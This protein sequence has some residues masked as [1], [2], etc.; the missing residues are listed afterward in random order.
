MD[1]SVCVRF[2]KRALGAV[3][4]LASSSHSVPLSVKIARNPSPSVL[5]TSGIRDLHGAPEGE[6]PE[7]KEGLRQGLSQPRQEHHPDRRDHPRRGHGRVDDRRGSHGRL[8]LRSLRRALP[9]PL[10]VRGAGGG[11]RWARC[12]QDGEGRGAHRGEGADLVFLPSYSH[13]LNPIEEAFSKIKHLVRKVGART[14]EALVE[15]MARAWAAVTTE[16]VAGWFAHAGYW[17]QDQPL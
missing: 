4:A 17:P 15:A 11:A 7:G 6:G 16:D 9:G 5:S 2:C 10:S 13:D 3:H 8:G 1:A 12:A 14:R